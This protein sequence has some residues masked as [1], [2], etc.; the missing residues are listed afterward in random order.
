MK[1]IQNFVQNEGW[2]N[3]FFQN[4]FL[5]MNPGQKNRF[6]K[7]LKEI[8]QLAFAIAMGPHNNNN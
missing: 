5:R 6:C 7:D 2:L 1:N 3:S 8:S 4:N